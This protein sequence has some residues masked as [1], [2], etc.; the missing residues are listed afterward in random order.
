LPDFER[1]AVIGDD[2][3]K[4]KTRLFADLLIECEENG[5]AEAASSGS[6]GRIARLDC[7]HQGGPGRLVPA[8]PA[9]GAQH[10]V[11]PQP[12]NGVVRLLDDERVIGLE[13]EPRPHADRG[14]R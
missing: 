9:S 3:A 2:W 12:D 4:P 13:A 14:V 8:R 5:A 7:Q 11:R 6:C 1:V 10:G